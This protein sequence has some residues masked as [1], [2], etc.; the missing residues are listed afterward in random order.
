M[1][2]SDVAAF[3]AACIAAL[4]QF[5]ETEE[6]K[7]PQNKFLWLDSRSA[8]ASI[9]NKLD[10]IK[11]GYKFLPDEIYITSFEEGSV[12]AR[13][14]VDL[15]AL[16]VTFNDRFDIGELQKKRRHENTYEQDFV[17]E[18]TRCILRISAIRRELKQ[19]HSARSVPVRILRVAISQL[20]RNFDQARKD[21]RTL[22][23]F[24]S[25][26]EALEDAQIIVSNLRNTLSK[27]T[28]IEGGGA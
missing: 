15:L 21:L 19:T 8:Q 25:P 26:R 14:G 17:T 13:T 23:D 5:Q 3:C 18:Y 22:V 1:A 6:K 20:Q 16:T 4:P 11:V 9:K 24:G 28:R 12:I 2:H 27:L 7:F 10:I